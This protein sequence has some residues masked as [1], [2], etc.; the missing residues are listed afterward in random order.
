VIS[1]GSNGRK[2]LRLM[3]SAGE[4]P[5]AETSAPASPAS[6]SVN[7]VGWPE[8][9]MAKADPPR[10]QM[11]ADPKGGLSSSMVLIRLKLMSG[12]ISAGWMLKGL[13]GRILSVLSSYLLCS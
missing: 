8:K 10:N 1:E 6:R 4:Y 2:T 7:M 5:R 13:R 11:D 12:R 3:L 9:R